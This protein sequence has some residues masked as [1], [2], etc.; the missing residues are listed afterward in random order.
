LE[1]HTGRKY[2][3]QAVWPHVLGDFSQNTDRVN[4][5]VGEERDDNE[6]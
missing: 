2:V 6:R 1:A 4:N 3:G 5:T